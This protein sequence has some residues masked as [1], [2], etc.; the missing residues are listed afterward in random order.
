MTLQAFV[1]ALGGIVVLCAAASRVPAAVADLLRACIPA[2]HA[3]RQLK[4]AWH[5]VDAVGTRQF[6]LPHPTRHDADE[7]IDPDD[8]GAE[9]SA[10]TT[11]PS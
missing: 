9:P 3:A 4:E 8:A 10:R 5:S 6:L 11:K 1:G 2:L 7:D